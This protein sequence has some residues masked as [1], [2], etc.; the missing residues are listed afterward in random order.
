MQ[1]LN[2]NGTVAY[3]STS[4]GGV[5]VRFAI[6]PVG[7]STDAQSITLSSAYRGMTITTYPLVSGDHTYYVFNGNIESGQ[8]P[9]IFWWNKRNVLDTTVRKQT[10][11]MVFAK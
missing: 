10:I 7:T 11:L 8:D 2:S 9:Q 4:P 3:D 5:F 6:F 1:V